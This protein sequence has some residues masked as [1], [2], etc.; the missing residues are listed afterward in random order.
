MTLS[1]TPNQQAWREFDET[2]C[3]ACGNAKPRFNAFCKPCYFKLDVPMRQAL[4][5]RFGQGFEEAY[6]EAKEYLI[7]ERKAKA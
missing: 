7:G 1:E 3:A 5:K 2:R 4:Y 6:F